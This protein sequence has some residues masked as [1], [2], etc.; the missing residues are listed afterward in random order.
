MECGVWKGGSVGLMVLANLKYSK[1]KRHI[2]MFDIFDDI[3]EPDPSVDGDIAIKQIAKLAGVSPD[4]FKGRLQSVKGAYDSHGGHG[5]VEVVKELM[6]DKIGYDKEFLH[7]YKGWFQETIPNAVGDIREIAILRLD[8]DWYASTKVCL[9]FLY[10]KVVPGGFVI[11]DD[12]GTY[13]GCRK[14]V[15]EF[16]EKQGIQNFLN[17]VNQDCRYW[18]KE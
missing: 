1:K 10:D 16:R 13:E 6:E 7:Y 15:D 18:I 2:H 4:S 3:C 14:A 5:T 9:N 12:Y 17:H 8:G 11:I